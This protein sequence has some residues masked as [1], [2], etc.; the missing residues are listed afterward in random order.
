MIVNLSPDDRTWQVHVNGLLSILRQSSSAT[1]SPTI[2][3]LTTAIQCLNSQKQINEYVA[4]PTMTSIDKASL[5]LSVAE[6][7]LKNIIDDMDELFAQSRAPRKIDIQ[8]LRKSLRQIQRNLILVPPLIPEEDGPAKFLSQEHDSAYSLAKSPKFDSS[9]EK[10][11][12]DQLIRCR[13]QHTLFE[14]ND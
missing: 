1:A 14:D 4:T 2:F 13:H 11:V 12:N 5:L 10:S 3:T 6:L 7:T 9:S 8:R